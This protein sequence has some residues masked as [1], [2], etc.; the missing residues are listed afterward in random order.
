[1]RE[2]FANREDQTPKPS[3][4]SRC[5]HSHFS[6]FNN[7]KRDIDPATMLSFFRNLTNIPRLVLH[8]EATELLCRASSRPSCRQIAP[9]FDENDIVESPPVSTTTVE[10]PHASAD[11]PATATT[12]A[13]SVN[14]EASPT[15][16]DGAPMSPGDHVNPPDRPT[17]SAGAD[18]DNASSSDVDVDIEAAATDADSE[19]S[20]PEA[21][22]TESTDVES[23]PSFDGHSLGVRAE[24]VVKTHRQRDRRLSHVK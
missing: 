16:P 21:L 11:L 2:P 12:N 9:L 15:S 22:A 17:P 6:F 10:V 3:L 23:L 13:T 1:M 4:H 18:E 8:Q 7:D 20:P 5:R 14:N 24:R 19:S